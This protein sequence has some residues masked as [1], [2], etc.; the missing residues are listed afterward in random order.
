MN[1][2]TPSPLRFVI[3]PAD[4]KA[5]EANLTE[6]A[7][8]GKK[9]PQNISTRGAWGGD[10]RGRPQMAQEL[11]EYV[12]LTRPNDRHFAKIVS[13]ARRLHRFLDSFA[14]D[15]NTQ[16]YTQLTDAHGQA[17]LIALTSELDSAGVYKNVK[18][19][20][21]C[22][23]R[24]T[25][26]PELYWPTRPIF[27]SF[28]PNKLDSTAAKKLYTGL[29]KEAMSIKT[30]FRE[31]DALA[32]RGTDPRL[33]TKKAW[34]IAE[35][36]AWILRE[37]T[38]TRLLS[39]EEY[40]QQGALRI[41]VLS[42][43]RRAGGPSYLAPGM[44]EDGNIGTSRKLRWFHPSLRDTAV[45][46]WLFLLG[47]GWNLSTALAIDVTSPSSWCQM[48]P[49]KPDFRVLHAP[50]GRSNAQM[51]A[52]SLAKP[53]WHPFKIVQYML[54]ITGPLRRTLQAS[55]DAAR[56]RFESEPTSRNRD[57]IDRIQT[58][59]KSPW[60]YLPLKDFSSAK[61]LSFDNIRA[62]ND[63]ADETVKRHELDKLHPELSAVSTS[64]ARDAWI[65]HA[66]GE[67]AHNA[68][69]AKLA[70]QHSNFA[71]LRHYVKSDRKHNEDAVRRVQNAAFDEILHKGKFDPTRLRLLTTNGTITEEQERRLL[72]MRQRTRL[73]F[74]CLDPRNP[75]GEVAPDHRKG[76]LCRVQRCTGCKHGLVFDE[77]LEALC[78]GLAELIH[79]KK[80]IPLISWKGSSFE[81]EENSI[82]RT[83]SL[84]DADDAERMTQFWI[85]RFSSGEVKVH[86]SYP[87]Y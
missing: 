22:I 67:S 12:R 55:L 25:D 68:L 43:K 60:L 41:A 28:D 75:P 45:F 56:A 58:D 65:T 70:A 15:G 19:L 40:D 21:Y 85:A 30:M 7:I 72:D 57:L 77:S 34:F 37:L 24:L 9:A 59:L 36:Q 47:T 79:L 51:F 42:K 80:D 16:S 82:R 86:E 4:G 18:Q 69:I 52:L 17:I 81:D 26:A 50:K 6:F 23:R 10:F 61:A 33:K 2:Q 39:L 32:N 53:E 29:K 78:R 46:L 38:K 63:I 8:G 13:S 11:A 74:G 20:V 71:S 14:S 76:D 73:G 64:D 5:Y 83:L 31:G 3:E 62:I 27:V 49:Q 87:S 1:A 35:N 84:F 66:Y 48:H 54:D 44:I